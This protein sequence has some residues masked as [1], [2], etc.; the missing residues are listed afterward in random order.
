MPES[1]MAVK[2]TASELGNLQQWMENETSSLA[3]FLRY[4]AQSYEKADCWL[5][6]FHLTLS[7]R[8]VYG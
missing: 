4:S 7:G 6:F 3:G 5:L 8:C 1:Q 2:K